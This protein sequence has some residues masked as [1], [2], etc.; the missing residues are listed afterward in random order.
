MEG[1][2]ASVFTDRVKSWAGFC[3]DCSHM[4]VPK[5]ISVV[6]ERHS[7]P[8]PAL[9]HVT[10][11]KSRDHPGDGEA[12]KTTKSHCA[13]K[14]EQGGVTKGEQREETQQRKAERENEVKESREGVF[15]CF[16]TR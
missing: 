15:F 1:E 16:V 13:G 3:L 10:S 7:S 14:R 8:W 2:G 4:S 6:G 9:C 5:P 11:A 12:L